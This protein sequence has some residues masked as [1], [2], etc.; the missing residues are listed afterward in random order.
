MSGVNQT[1]EGPL[2][3]VVWFYPALMIFK[4]GRSIPIF[5]LLVWDEYYT[6]SSSLKLVIDELKSQISIPEFWHKTQFITFEYFAVDH[7]GI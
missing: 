6:C 7:L 5:L 2:K 1:R 4:A 3:S